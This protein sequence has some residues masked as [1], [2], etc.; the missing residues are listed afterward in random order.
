MNR[1]P[2]EY[3]RAKSNSAWRV[4]GLLALRWVV[5]RY[6]LDVAMS[7][8]RGTLL[9]AKGSEWRQIKGAL[10]KDPKVFGLSD[11]IGQCGP[12]SASGKRD[13]FGALGEE[14]GIRPKNEEGRAL[15]FWGFAMMCIIVSPF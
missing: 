2:P 13:R 6:I 5:I 7:Q 12:S 8:G 9:K 1:K 15:I 14:G 3:T 10:Q 4:A 11:C